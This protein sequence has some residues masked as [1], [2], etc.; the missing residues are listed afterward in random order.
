MEKVW[1]TIN[2]GTNPADEHYVI[3]DFSCA[4]FTFNKETDFEIVS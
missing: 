1:Y 3:G 4:L 2:L